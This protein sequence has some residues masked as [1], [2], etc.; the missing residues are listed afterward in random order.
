MPASDDQ[1]ICALVESLPTPT[2]IRSAVRAGITNE[3]GDVYREV[4][5]YNP[6][7]MLHLT[8]KLNSLGFKSDRA[9][10]EVRASHYAIVFSRRGRKRR[11]G[12]GDEW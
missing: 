11:G 3:Q 9:L 12:S 8:A 6:L 1:R 7:E 5:V 10:R 4:L 2:V